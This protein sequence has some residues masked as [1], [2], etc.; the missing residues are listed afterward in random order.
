MFG[1]LQRYPDG[2]RSAAVSE[3][4]LVAVQVVA[5]FH[6]E[7]GASEPTDESWLA[8]MVSHV[9]VSQSVIRL[10]TYAALSGGG[11]CWPAS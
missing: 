4:G 10:I 2:A 9:G 7:S 11:R 6:S 1:S 3:N 5:A 8:R